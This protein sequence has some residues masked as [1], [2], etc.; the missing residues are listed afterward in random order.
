MR[1]ARGGGQNASADFLSQSAPGWNVD[2]TTC[3]VLQ[4]LHQSAR[5]SH[6]TPEKLLML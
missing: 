2:G 1:A 6:K 3:A 5:P 4:T